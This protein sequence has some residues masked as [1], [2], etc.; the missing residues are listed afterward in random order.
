MSQARPSAAPGTRL[1]TYLELEKIVAA[2]ARGYLNLLIVI[3][4]HGLGKSRIVRQALAGP[5]C[6]LEGNLSVFGLYCQ[7]WEHR[8]LPVVL[9]DVDG[10]YAQRHGVR[11]LK[12]LTQS[13]SSK[14]VSWHTDAPTLQR[15]A[16]PQEFQ[17][18]SRVAIIANEWKMLNR[19]VAALQDRGHVLCFE[20]SPLEVHRQT[21]TWFWDQDIFDFVGARLAW[22]AEASMRHYLAAW[23]LKQA[24]LDWR[25]LL[26]SRCLSGRALLVAQVKADPQYRSEA[27]RVEAFLAAGGGSRSTYFNWS[28]KLQAAAT[29]PAICLRNQPPVAKATDT[30]HFRNLGWRH[31][32]FGEN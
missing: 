18:S 10:L 14:R 7:L 31:G 11:L 4:G 12:C 3:G 2:F 8:H 25:S 23:E 1:T 22:L 16:I 30:D 32:L 15:Q 20:P 29:A 6:W 13:E 9:D 5:V 28:R 27:E 17:T 19:N 26:L 24:G 21:A